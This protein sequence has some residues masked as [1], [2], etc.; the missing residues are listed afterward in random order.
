MLSCCRCMSAIWLCSCASR[1]SFS[2]C[3]CLTTISSACHPR[4]CQN[5]TYITSYC[6]AMTLLRIQGRVVCDRQT[7]I[8]TVQPGNRAVEANKAV[9]ATCATLGHNTYPQQL[10]HH[11]SDLLIA[12][13]ELQQLVTHPVDFAR[14]VSCILTWPMWFSKYVHQ[15]QTK[16]LL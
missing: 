8:F 4:P 9:H 5:A 7:S 11:R 6:F 2:A 1:L 15:P 14:G 13:I 10:D 3:T 12:I 16:S